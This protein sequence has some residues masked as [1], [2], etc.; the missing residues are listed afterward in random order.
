MTTFLLVAVLLTAATLALLLR[1]W[2]RRR[3]VAA[4][5]RQALNTAIYRDQLAELDKD[6]AAGELT[7][8]DYQEARAELQ[9][10][11][12]EDTAEADTTPAAPPSARSLAAVLVLLPLLALGAYAWLGNP[13]GLD[14]TVRQDFTADDIEKMVA[15]LAERLE[16]EPE[17]YPGWVMLARSYK[18]MRRYDPAVQ[19]Y[20]KAMPLVQQEPQLLAD[21][22]DLLAMQAGGKLEGRP[23][24]LI[25]QAL[26]LDPKH[27]QSLWLAGTAAFNRKDFGQAAAYWQRGLDQL[28]PASEDAKMLVGIIAEAKQKQGIA[29]QAAATAVSGRVELAAAVKDQ[30]AAGDTV[31]VLAK[32]DGNQIGRASCRERV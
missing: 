9:R 10:R 28:D 19:A 2:W 32:E 16:Q 26:T 30:A 18:A 11:L 14:A 8:A 31:F 27:M 3:P 4:A 13:A 24:Q 12:L 22:A 6:R 23:E 1:P 5:S 17:N 25:G 21:F 15:G 20:E 7:E 29:K